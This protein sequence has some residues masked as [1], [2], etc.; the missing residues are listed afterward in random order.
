MKMKNWKWGILVLIVI[1][2]QSSFAGAQNKY[3]LDKAKSSLKVTGTS[4]LHDWHMAVTDFSGSFTALFNE[5]M[6]LVIDAGDFVCDAASITSDNS[7]MDDK[8]HNALKTDRYKKIEF[9]LSKATALVVNGG[10]IDSQIGGQ[11]QIS[12]QKHVAT[13]PIKGTIDTDGNVTLKG[14]VDVKMSD[15]SIKPP[16]ALMGA[17]K[18][19]DD[20]TIHYQFYFLK[21]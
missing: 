9:D 21:K 6:D 7:L 17:V 1:L 11:L 14:E 12:G 15:Y 4:T 18:S 13:L 3:V 8:A 2:F 20:V 16:T 5:N 10:T 19:G